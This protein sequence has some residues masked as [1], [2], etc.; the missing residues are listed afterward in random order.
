MASH[1]THEHREWHGPAFRTRPPASWGGEAAVRIL[2]L[3]K[4]TAKIQNTVKVH[5][6]TAAA[7]LGN[8]CQPQPSVVAL[9]PSRQSRPVVEV[10]A[11]DPVVVVRRRVR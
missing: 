9:S 3:D 6:A 11:S 7:A 8:R 10:E 1:A 5:E 4:I 2:K